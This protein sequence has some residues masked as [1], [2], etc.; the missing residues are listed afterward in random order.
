MKMDINK[1]VFY[2]TEYEQLREFFSQAIKKL[3]EPLIII[4]S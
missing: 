2:V 1:E 3:S 4:K